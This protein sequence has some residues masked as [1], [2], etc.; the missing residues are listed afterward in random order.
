MPIT[1][2]RLLGLISAGED[3]LRALLQVETILKRE[4][5][6]GLSPEQTLENLKLFLQPDLL[7]ER[8]VETKTTIALERQKMSPTRQGVN[9][10]ARERQRKRRHLEREPVQ[11]QEPDFE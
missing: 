6:L 2:H 7:L 10:R 4:L 9:R 5:L 1:E 11:Q 8:P 3:A